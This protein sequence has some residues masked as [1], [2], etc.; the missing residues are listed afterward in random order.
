MSFESQCDRPSEDDIC[1]MG[2]SA[3]SFVEYSP[4]VF[5]LEDMGISTD[6]ELVEVVNKGTIGGS[7]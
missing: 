3:L 4:G 2:V 6:E 7:T 5:S 1:S